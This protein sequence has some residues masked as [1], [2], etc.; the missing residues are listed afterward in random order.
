MNVYNENVK[1]DSLYNDLAD[2][3][4]KVDADAADYLLEE[5][6][7][8]PCFC[9]SDILISCFNWSKTPQG[10]EYWFNINEELTNLNI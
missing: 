2:R 9:Y 6:I 3:V 4:R 7:K 8:L 10:H 5:A 1:K